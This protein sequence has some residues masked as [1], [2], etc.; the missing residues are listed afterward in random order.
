ML[1]EKLLKIKT[2][3]G[4]LGKDANNPF[5]K[6]KYVSLSKIL[7]TINPLLAENKLLLTT[8][9]DY[10]ENTTLNIFTITVNIIDLEDGSN[11][12]FNYST[13]IDS[14][15]SNKI[16]AYGSTT[17]YGQRYALAMLFGI[18]FDDEDSDQFD[19]QPKRSVDEDAKTLS[20]INTILVDA[21]RLGDFEHIFE[22]YKT[23][24][25]VGRKTIW[26]SIE[27][28]AKSLDFNY[29]RAKKCFIYSEAKQ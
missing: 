20:A 8:T 14:T 11:K 21:T 4:V 25:A 28:K 22:K 9:I 7:R 19:P 15:Q 12:N 23:L 18:P 10:R 6:S 5:H 2:A 27:S 13:P 16:Q 29:D 3:I 24:S 17:T 26:F 1:N